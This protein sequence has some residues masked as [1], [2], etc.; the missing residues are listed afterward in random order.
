MKI[1][2]IAGSGDL[3]LYLARENPKAFVMCID[4]FSDTR[5]IKNSSKTVSLLNPD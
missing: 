3:P 2:L 4:G 1:G 5:F